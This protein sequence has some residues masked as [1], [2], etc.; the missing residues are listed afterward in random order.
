MIK[1]RSKYF[2]LDTIK[3]AKP[4]KVEWITKD[5]TWDCGWFN[6]E[7]FYSVDPHMDEIILWKPLECII[8]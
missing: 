2:N 6:G 4:M 8:S 7:D 1:D 3:P 5:G